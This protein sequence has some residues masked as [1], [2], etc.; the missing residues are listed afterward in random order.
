[1][2]FDCGEKT[3]K[4]TILYMKDPVGKLTAFLKRR[5]RGLRRGLA[6]AAAGLCAALC[7]PARVQAAEPQDITAA[8]WVLI[9]ASTGQVL[10][11]KQSDTRMYPASITKILTVALAVEKG[12]FF[13]DLWE[14]LA[15]ENGDLRAEYAQPDGYHLL[16]EGYA[17]WVEYLRT[18][19][20][21]T[22]PVEGAASAAEFEGAERA[23]EAPAEK[24]DA[25]ESAAA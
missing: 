5:G 14:V 25:A 10:A 6:C 12:C 18:H 1:M 13:L 22:R 15:D 4:G 21:H 7:M 23:G 19:T 17:A 9:D 20:A 2:P 3:I 11:E 8:A 24:A 16:P